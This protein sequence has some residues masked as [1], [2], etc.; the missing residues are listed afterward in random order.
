[1]IF[2]SY[3]Y[4][5]ELGRIAARMEKRKTLKRWSGN[6]CFL[7]EKDFFTGFFIIR[8]LIEAKT[9][10]TTAFV[11]QP[12]ALL[13]HLPTGYPPTLNNNHIPE[14]LYNLNVGHTI[15]AA[16]PFICNQAIHSYIF[17]P[18]F[19]E[20]GFLVSILFNSFHE[21]KTALYEIS[22]DELIDLFTKVSQNFSYQLHH[23]LNKDGDY[24]IWAG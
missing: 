21:R 7:L 13:K 14:K 1:M 23:R 5:K 20:E 22:M 9:K 24:D 16:L 8:K 6:P 15:H 10:L 12:V 17:H 3:P 19:S 11:Q 2:E 18:R 4:K